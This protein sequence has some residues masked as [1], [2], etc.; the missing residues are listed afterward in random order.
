MVVPRGALTSTVNSSCIY[1]MQYFTI[2][3]R[4]L[5]HLLIPDTHAKWLSLFDA[6]DRTDLIME[7]ELPQLLNIAFINR[8]KEDLEDIFKTLRNKLSSHHDPI[9]LQVITN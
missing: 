6:A 4:G 3:G 2:T 9:V 5:D 7:A 1:K 8:R